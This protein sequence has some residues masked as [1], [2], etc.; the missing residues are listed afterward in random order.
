MTKRGSVDV[1][2][3]LID[4]YD[5]LGVSTTLNDNLEALIQETTTFGTT[6]ATQAPTGVKRAEISQ[7]GYYD[8]AS[9]S[10]NDALSGQE[11]VSRLL[12]YGLEGNTIGKQF[13]GYS[14]AMQVNYTKIATRGE[15]HRANASYQGDGDVEKGLILHP[16]LLKDGDGNTES[17]GVEA[18]AQTTAGGV[19]YLQVSELDLDGLANVI[20]K[21]RESADGIAWNDLTSFTAV[22]AAPAKER[23]AIT[24]TVKKHLAVSWAFAG[25]TT[26][27]PSVKFMVGFKRK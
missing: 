17:A 27:N 8:D 19:A 22:T 26:E 12:S 25:L 14:G 4:G 13:V 2:F 9:G 18:A 10:I 20:I 11:G 3:L 7:E 6:W 15:I 21:I 16:H 23:K 5:L 1:G 24:G